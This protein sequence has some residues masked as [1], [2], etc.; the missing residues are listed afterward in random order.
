VIIQ[1]KDHGEG[2]IDVERFTANDCFGRRVGRESQRLI[3]GVAHVIRAECVSALRASVVGGWVE[4]NDNARLASNRSHLTDQESRTEQFVVGLEAW[5]EVGD[6]YAPAL[7]V[8]QP[9]DEYGSIV[10]VVLLDP[11]HSLELD[12]KGASPGVGGV[13]AEKGTE[14]GITIEAREAAP[15]D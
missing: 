4:T 8:Y 14:N 10:D 13:A 12:G 11:G 7:R 2:S 1:A 3:A 6:L 5:T 15:D 9:G